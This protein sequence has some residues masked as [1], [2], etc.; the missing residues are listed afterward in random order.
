MA[1]ANSEL[2]DNARLERERQA[3][4][5]IVRERIRDAAIASTTFVYGLNTICETRQSS[6]ANVLNSILKNFSDG[7]NAGAGNE[8]AGGRCVG[9]GSKSSINHRGLGSDATL[10]LLD[11]LRLRYTSS[12]HGGGLSA[13]PVPN[14]SREATDTAVAGFFRW[15]TADALSGQVWVSVT[16]FQPKTAQRP[17]VRKN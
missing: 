5:S 8:V 16:A 4:D 14:G 6:V 13:I 11:G 17:A 7:L 12:A 15:P 2:F 3:E 9:F 10:M 1:R